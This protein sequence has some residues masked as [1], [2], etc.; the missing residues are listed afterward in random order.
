MF[1]LTLASVL[2]LGL[3]ACASSSARHA[4]WA[5]DS[6]NA[7]WVP[8]K[9]RVPLGNKLALEL[10]ATGVQIY[11]CQPT[12]GDESKFEW[13]LKSPEARLT[14][15]GGHDAGHHSAGPTWESSDGSKVVGE[16]EQKFDLPWTGS[17]PWLLLSAKS[18]EGNGEL[19]HVTF[20]QRLHTRGGKAPL[21]GA[22]AAHVGGELRVGYSAS[23]YF[24]VA[25]S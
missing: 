18:N 15:V 23:Y 9:L 4:E 6:R 13:T 10:H 7:L 12:A 1:K 22:D 25:D 24:Y 8:A 11:T 19:G 21:E 16:M 5:S 17:I 20:I 14:D 2:A 3:V